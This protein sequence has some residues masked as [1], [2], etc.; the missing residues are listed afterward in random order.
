[1][2]KDE[3]QIWW[4]QTSVQAGDTVNTTT[5]EV[6]FASKPQPFMANSFVAGDCIRFRARGLFGAGGLVVAAYTFRIKLGSVALATSAAINTA[7]GLTSKPWTVTGE[8]SIS[9]LGASGTMECGGEAMLSLGTGVQAAE[10]MPTS[11]VTV[12]TTVDQQFQL[13]VQPSISLLANTV[14]LR[15]F[16]V[17]KL[18]S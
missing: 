11:A 1:M 18:R 2:I 3:N 9:A 16:I 8:I 5:G 13:S 10:F 12:D 4:S 17:E 7:L 6:V 14:T 15:Q